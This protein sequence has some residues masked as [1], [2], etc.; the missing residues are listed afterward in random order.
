MADETEAETEITKTEKKAT[1]PIGDAIIDS[2]VPVSNTSSGVYTCIEAIAL[3]AT[4]LTTNQIARKMRVT[5]AVAA[6]YVRAGKTSSEVM[7]RLS[8]AF[9]A[10]VDVAA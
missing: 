5:S 3:D 4:G 9:R 7:R 2:T 1:K 8:A 6:R 10:G